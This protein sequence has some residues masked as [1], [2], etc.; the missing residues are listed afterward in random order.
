MIF[1]PPTL[2]PPVITTNEHRDLVRG[3]IASLAS[4][5][6]K[7]ATKHVAD[8]SPVSIRLT[9]VSKSGNFDSYVNVQFPNPNGDPRT[10]SL[11]VDSGNATLIVPYYEDLENLPGYK[12]LGKAKEPWGCMANVVQGPIQI[13]TADGSLYE[14]EN[15]VFYACTA[16]NEDGERTSNFGAGRVVPWSANGWNTPPGLDITMQSPLS[17]KTAYPYVEFVYAPAE[18]MLST[19]ENVLVNDESVMVQRAA[20]PLGYTMLDIIPKL[21]WMSVVPASLMIGGTKTGWP[22][23]VAGPIAMIDNGGGPLFLSDPDGYVYKGPWPDKVD[24]P[25]WTQS[26]L[27][28]YCIGDRLHV[29]LKSPGS[30]AS[31]GYTIDTSIMPPSVRHLTAVMCRKNEF[32]MGNQGMNVGG[33]TA[34]FNRILIDYA[35]SRVG[36]APKYPNMAPTVEMGSSVYE[37]V[38]VPP[39]GVYLGYDLLPAGKVVNTTMTISWKEL[40]AGAT[41]VIQHPGS[42]GAEVL[43]WSGPD[44]SNAPAGSLVAAF[45]VKRTT[46]SAVPIFIYVIKDNAYLPLS[47]LLKATTK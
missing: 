6:P 34:L 37:Q 30:T 18:T 35:G 16:D 4:F 15:C 39:P 24:C 41:L 14:I 42:A 32:M 43:N 31:Y 17:Y 46:G 19:T 26:S 8:G 3:R 40:P 45:N 25:G 29:G 44:Y 12:V 21:A 10:V 9:T 27:D 38:S 23:N 22:G 11:L 33:I 2:H 20:V 13:V 5:R 47:F 28:C 7:P 36:L 1:S